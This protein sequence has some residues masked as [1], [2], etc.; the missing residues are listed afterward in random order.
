ML[1]NKYIQASCNFK[2]ETEIQRFLLKYLTA[3]L[4]FQIMVKA[5]SAILILLM[6]H[7]RLNH[8][9]QF[10][11]IG[12]HLVFANC[13]PLI[14]KFMDQ[15]MVRYVQSKHELPPYNY[16]HAPLYYARNRG[17][18]SFFILVKALFMIFKITSAQK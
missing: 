10:E 12:Q 4:N 5:A 2:K 17:E 3:F 15:N 16:P 11:Y 18:F 9:Y 13:I 6:K 14:L 8:I 1:G 7:F